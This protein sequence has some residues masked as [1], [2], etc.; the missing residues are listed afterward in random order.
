MAHKATMAS[1]LADE[2]DE[3]E[4]DSVSVKAR[5]L[6]GEVI[7]R[8]FSGRRHTVQVRPR[9]R[10]LRLHAFPLLTLCQ[11]LL[12]W[13]GAQDNVPNIDSIDVKFRRSPAVLI[14]VC[15]MDQFATLLEAFGGAVNA[16]LTI[17]EVLSCYAGCICNEAFFETLYVQRQIE[18]TPGQQRIENPKESSTTNMYKNVIIL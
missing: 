8:R 14:S 17:V 15:E 13:I 18:N 4:Y 12:V 6:S 3:D 11:D 16:S 5:L 1:F 7:R 2:P 10:F 9:S